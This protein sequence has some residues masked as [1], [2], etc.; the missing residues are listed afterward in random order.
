VHLSSPE[1]VPFRDYHLKLSPDQVHIFRINIEECYT[2][3]SGD[4][5]DILSERELSKASKF[6]HLSDKKNYLVRKFFLRR[7]LACFSTQ[8]PEKLQFSQ[9]GNRK[10]SLNNIQFNVSHSKEYA[11]IVVHSNPIGVDIEYIDADFAFEPILQTCFDFEEQVFVANGEARL[12]FYTLWTRKEAILKATG[13]GLIDNLSSVGCLNNDVIR[14]GQTY[15][16]TTLYCHKHYLLSLATIG[17]SKK[18]KHWH[19][20]Q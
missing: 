7:I 19:L 20:C 6:L 5:R 2:C 17:G 8:A 4:L 12:R 16:I 9:I 18:L 10:P 11:V 13:E 1:W 15:Q 3:I 14:H